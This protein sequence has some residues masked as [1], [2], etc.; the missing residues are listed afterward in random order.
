[1]LPLA[2]WMPWLPG[3]LDAWIPG[4]LAAWLPG[5]LDAWLPGCLAA[6]L[7]GRLAGRPAGWPAGQLA[8]PQARTRRAMR[9]LSVQNIGA[10]R[11]D[12]SFWNAIPS[13]AR[14]ILDKNN[15]PLEVPAKC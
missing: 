12:P 7:P 14:E 10:E 6:W 15:S 13:R 2:A 1:M 4:C 3:C 8:S 11:Q 5:C 9:D